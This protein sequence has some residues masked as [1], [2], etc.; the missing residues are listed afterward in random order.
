MIGE[1][2]GYAGIVTHHKLDKF[3]RTVKHNLFVVRE[4]IFPLTVLLSSVR[5]LTSLGQDVLHFFNFIKGDTKHLH[6]LVLIYIDR[7][8]CSSTII[9]CHH[10]VC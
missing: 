4:V 10:T 2:E 9:K 6:V 5:T 1:V 7:E 3:I 8:H